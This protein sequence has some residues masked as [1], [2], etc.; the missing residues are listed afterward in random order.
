[1]PDW[2]D[3]FH[4]PLLPASKTKS[5]TPPIA[6]TSHDVVIKTVIEEKLVSHPAK[7]IMRPIRSGQQVYAEGDLIVIASVGAGAEVLADGNIHVYG[8][9]RGRALAGVKGDVSARIFCKSMEAE[10]VSIAGNFML[11]DALQTF[12]WKEAAQVLLNDDNLLI[13]PL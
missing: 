5:I 7:V 6:Q 2:S 12:V 4:L 13:E 3:D 10:L 1:M 8:A 11:S 9:L